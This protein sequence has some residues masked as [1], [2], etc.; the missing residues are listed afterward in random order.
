MSEKHKEQGH[1]PEPVRVTVSF[2]LNEYARLKEIVQAREPL[3]VYIARAALADPLVLEEGKNPEVLG[4]LLAV[5]DDLAL[6]VR[7]Q[8]LGDL[9]TLRAYDTALQRFKRSPSSG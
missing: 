3:A 5:A 7:S 6:I 8:G 1:T 9:A 2:T 4:E